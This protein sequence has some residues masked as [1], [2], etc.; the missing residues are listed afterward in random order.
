MARRVNAYSMS[1]PDAYGNSMGSMVPEGTI[2]PGNKLSEKAISSLSGYNSTMDAARKSV[3]GLKDIDKQKKK[4][5]DWGEFAMDS[6]KELAGPASELLK[7]KVSGGSGGASAGA[8]DMSALKN[9][10]LNSSNGAANME[11]AKD[12]MS[13]KGAGMPGVGMAVGA[14]GKIGGEA[15]KKGGHEGWGGALSGAATGASMGMAAG[16]IGMAVGAGVGAIA[17]GI[18]GQMDKKKRLRQEAKDE[19]AR[20]THNK[21]VKDM[22]NKTIGQAQ[23]LAAYQG[24]L[25]AAKGGV[26]R[27]KKGGLLY[28]ELNVAEA[29][30]YLNSLKEPNKSSGKLEDVPMFQMGGAIAGSAQ[31]QDKQMQLFKTAYQMY[32]DGISIPDIA[33]KL[34]IKPELAQKLIKAF[35]EKDKA[36]TK[37]SPSNFTTNN[38]VNQFKKGGKAPTFKKGGKTTKCKKGCKCKSCLGKGTNMALIFRRGGKVDLEKTNVIIDGPSHE[39]YNSTGVK[40]DKGLPVVKNGKK[41]AEIESDELVINAKSAKE[42][43]FLRNKAKKGDKKAK[44]EL[45]E[46]LHKELAHNTYDYSNVMK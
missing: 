37:K 23:D 35:T 10:G 7:S 13:G 42:I 39:D 11:G 5:I 25:S 20:L 31:Q 8:T 28:G 21:R 22:R 6:A 14:A 33:T 9:A 16:P 4:P 29:Q 27:Y 15:L 44:E 24:I 3:A 12:A 41:V 46:L 43:E 32:K 19:T 45:A 17:G 2:K 38:T 34:K 40:G 26:I 36:E 1:Q 30:A 18:K